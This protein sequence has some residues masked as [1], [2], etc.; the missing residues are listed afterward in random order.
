MIGPP[1]DG[2]GPVHFFAAALLI[3]QR[4][5]ARTAPIGRQV[6][7]VFRYDRTDPWAI[8][9]VVGAEHLPN[10]GLP[11]TEWRFAREMLD[12]GR[13]MAVGGD[14]GDVRIAPRAHR[15][16]VEIELRDRAAGRRYTL[17]VELVDVEAALAVADAIVPLAAEP[18]VHA[19]SAAVDAEL[20]AIL[21][22]GGDR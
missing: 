1:A 20:A 3:E 9:F 14:P 6:G 17:S 15:R 5:G 8:T 18:Y 22:A 13:V 19:S 2:F 7:I 11:R 4:I 16:F 21:A 10:R 12:T